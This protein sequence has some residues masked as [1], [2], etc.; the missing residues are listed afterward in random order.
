[1]RSL[2]VHHEG[3][4]DTKVRQ[5]RSGMWFLTSYLTK[6]SDARLKSI[7]SSDPDYSDPPMSNA[8]LRNSV[9]PEFRS[10]LS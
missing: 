5:R 3:A 7:V 9:D 10:K 8:W 6:S 2:A 4:K 1:M